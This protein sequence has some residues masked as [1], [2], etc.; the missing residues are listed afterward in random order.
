MN[1][2][3]RQLKIAGRQGRVWTENDLQVIKDLIK[4]GYSYGKI[5]SLFGVSGNTIR[6]LSLKYKWREPR[7]PLSPEQIE[8]VKKHVLEKKPLYEIASMFGVSDGV[9]ESLNK[10]Y[11]WRDFEKEKKEKDK[12]IIGLYLLPPEGKGMSAKQIR[13]QYGIFNRRVHIALDRLGL[14]D[15]WRSGHEAAKRRHEENPE[16]RRQQGETL[17]RRYEEDPELRERMSELNKQHYIDNPAL[18]D[19]ISQRMK[20]YWRNYPGGYYAWLSTFPPEKQK[21]IER[22]RSTSSNLG[23]SS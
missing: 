7:K 5:A 19:Q 8:E 9:I 2:Y 13:D 1:W 10:K 20:E 12:F 15:K 4:E 11:K 22:G 17:K 3:N 23:R 14:S 6:D 16:I 18:K 21:E